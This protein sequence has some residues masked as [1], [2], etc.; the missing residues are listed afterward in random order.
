MT[1]KFTTVTTRK[2]VQNY[3]NEKCTYNVNTQCNLPYALKV[4]NC[5]F[6]RKGYFFLIKLLFIKVRCLMNVNVNLEANLE[7][8]G[9]K[10]IMFTICWF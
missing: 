4:G 9:Y 7:G 6:E 10:T 8:Q 1:K 3:Y 2:N 5:L